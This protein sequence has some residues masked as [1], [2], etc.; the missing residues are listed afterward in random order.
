M[1]LAV[2]LSSLFTVAAP[3]EPAKPFLPASAHKSLGDKL[4]KYL[5]AENAYDFAEKARERE[6]AGKARRKAK[7][8]FE[9]EWAKAE[10]KGEVLGSMPDLRAIFHNCFVR[11]NP[12][13]SK[14]QFARRTYKTPRGDIEY[15]LMI[16]K[17]Y[18]ATTPYRTIVALPGGESGTWVSPT[19]YFK[20]TWDGSPALSDS[21]LHM[22]VLPKG[23]ELD[24]VPDYSREGAEQEEDRRN[25]TVLGSLGFVMHNYNVDRAR[26]FLDCGHEACGYGLRLATLFPDR[27]AGVILRDPVPVDELRLGNLLGLPILMLE[28]DANRQVVRALEQRIG[29]TCPGTVTVLAAK[30]AYPHKESGDDILAWMSDKKRDMTPKHVVIEPNHDRFQRAYWVNILV[31]DSLLTTG[32]DEKPRIEVQADRE[33]NRITVDARGVERFE[34]LLNDDLIDLG[35][36]FTVVINGKAVEEQRRRS[37]REMKNRM[38]TRGDWDYLFPVRYVASVPKE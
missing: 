3:Q 23:L 22:P 6:K 25:F 20:A 17:K 18:R 2:T 30:G 13:H 15:G 19:E 26:V 9:K 32:P 7:E 8:S 10:K 35:K 38:V 4:R 12:K 16:P 1:F 29:E 33:S 5:A 11:E 37:F 28:T 36:K 21:I 24:P 27:F 14:G 31:A 34:L